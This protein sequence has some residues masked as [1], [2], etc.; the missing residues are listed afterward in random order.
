MK[1]GQLDFNFFFFFMLL[2]LFSLSDVHIYSVQ[3]TLHEDKDHADFALFLYFQNSTKHLIS[4]RL[5]M[6]K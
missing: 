4:I 1:A 3:N 2:E 5:S 6:N